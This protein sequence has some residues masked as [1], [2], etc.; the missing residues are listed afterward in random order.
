MA[1]ELA[2][3]LYLYTRSLWPVVINLLT[4]LVLTVI[5]TAAFSF[6][7]LGSGLVACSATFGVQILPLVLVLLRRW[8]PSKDRYS[9]FL[10]QMAVEGV[11]VTNVV[12]RVERR[13]GT[14]KEVHAGRERLFLF[15]NK[16]VAYVIPRRVFSDD[17]EWQTFV[18]AV[19]ESFAKGQAEGL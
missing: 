1:D 11:I 8:G 17:N 18:T 7:V 16:A 10:F 3:W 12:A 5:L 19:R 2:V 13:W 14:F 15:L 4:A 6:P 9:T